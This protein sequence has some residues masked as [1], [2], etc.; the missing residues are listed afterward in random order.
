VQRLVL[1]RRT[2]IPAVLLVSLTPVTA[3]PL[4]AATLHCPPRLP[5]PHPGFEQIG[6]VPTAHWLLWRLQLINLP[7]ADTTPT[8]LLPAPDS[9]RR[10][11]FT[12][13]WHPTG[14]G[15]VQ[16]LC[17]YDGSATYYRARFHPPPTTCTLQNDNGL[18]QGWCEI[19]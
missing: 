4:A 8:E 11:G 14:A 6:P 5:G 2:M 19:P 15:D 3:R 9:V 7:P 17:L 1:R 10:D 12:L 18:A 13:T 16:M